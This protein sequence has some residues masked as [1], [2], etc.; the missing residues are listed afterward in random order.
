MAHSCPHWTG[1]TTH[2]ALGV[3]VGYVLRTW[4]VTFVRSGLR[5]S[6]KLLLR[7]DL[8]LKGNVHALQALFPLRRRLLLVRGLLRKSRTLRLSLLLPSFLQKGGFSG[9]GGLEMHLVLLSMGL[10]LLPLDLCPA[11]RVEVLLDARVLCVSELVSSA[12]SRAEDVEAVCSQWMP[13]ARSAPSSVA[14]PCS[15]LH[16]LRGDE[17]RESS[18]ACSHSRS[19]RASRSSA[20]EALKDCR[21][22][23]RSGSS[24]GWS[25][26]CRSS[27][28]SRSRASWAGLV[29]IAVFPCAVAAGSVAVFGPLPIPSSSL[30]LGFSV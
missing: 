28:C 21:A 13:V 27:S 25:R 5:C 22:R 17:L 24:R 11:R 4:H 19:S 12:P 6:G 15:S 18:E 1:I 3:G 29:S 10:P 2:L 23:S 30:A 26:C 8:M 14:S 16:A 7:K 9:G 20:R